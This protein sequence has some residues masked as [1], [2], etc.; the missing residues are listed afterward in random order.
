MSLSREK[1]GRWITITPSGGEGVVTLAF[2]ES[3]EFSNIALE[4]SEP[5]YVWLFMQYEGN[6]FVSC[7]KRM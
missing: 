6:R 3:R 7:K 5:G 2:F 4:R 1:N